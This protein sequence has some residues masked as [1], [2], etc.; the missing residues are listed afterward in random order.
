ML[1]DIIPGARVLVF[2][3]QPIDWIVGAGGLVAITQ[4]AGGLVEVIT[5]DRPFT[6]NPSR[7]HTNMLVA[8]GMLGVHSSES[9]TLDELGW[10]LEVDVYRECVRIIRAFKPWIILTHGDHEQAV[11]FLTINRLVELARVTAGQSTYPQLGK[12]WSTGLVLYFETEQPIPRPH[13]V[14]DTTST[15]PIKRKALLRLANR[16][17]RVYQRAL[18]LS[19]LRGAMIDCASGEAYR[20]SDCQPCQPDI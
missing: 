3:H 13:I 2:S 9:W 5:F 6:N 16:R 1:I 15:M 20:I 7:Y 18:G 8:Y 4:E 10:H 12:P 17:H 11:E 14:V 19:K